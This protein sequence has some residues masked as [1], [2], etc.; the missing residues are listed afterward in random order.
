MNKSFGQRVKDRREEL[1]ITQERLAY[2][3]GI[4]RVG[5]T[6]IEL[7]QTKNARA[8]TLLAIARALHCDPEWLLTGKASKLSNKKT[9]TNIEAGPII[10]QYVPEIN[11]VQ[12]GD[13][14]I[15]EDDTGDGPMHPCPVKCSNLTFAL[16]IKGDSME[17][18]FEEGDLIF[19]DPEQLDPSSGKFIVAQMEGNSEAT[20]KQLQITDGQKML[21]A[22][23]PDYPPDMRYVKINGNCRIVG[24][25]V[26]HVK[27]V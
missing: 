27:P 20:F 2:L 5:I 6:K 23:N 19:I 22:L 18:R 12:A 10:H 17:P 16:R 25:V 21:K 3:V 9:N 4:T 13:W 14:T 24:T 1:D 7:D 8:N 26:S 15:T 11:W